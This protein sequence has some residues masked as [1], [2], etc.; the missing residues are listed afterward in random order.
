MSHKKTEDACDSTHNMADVPSCSRS[1]CVMQRSCIGSCFHDLAPCS[2]DQWGSR[3]SF[4]GQ[5]AEKITPTQNQNVHITL[6]TVTIGWEPWLGTWVGCR[7]LR[8][9]CCDW[10]SS[11]SSWF[12][13]SLR[14][15]DTVGRGRRAPSSTAAPLATNTQSQNFQTYERVG[16]I[17]TVLVVAPFPSSALGWFWFE[18]VCVGIRRLSETGRHLPRHDSKIITT[19]TMRRW[20]N[21]NK[22]DQNKLMIWLV[23]LVC[24]PW[25]FYAAL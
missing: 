8:W 10:A 12:E 13:L 14:P 22:I 16:V 9:A 7:V 23:R 24:L 18:R 2:L 21:S 25:G 3:F 20:R 5:T 19:T 6:A 4:L 15:P 17:W 1:K 11:S